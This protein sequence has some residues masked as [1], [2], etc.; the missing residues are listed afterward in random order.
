MKLKVT[1][2][3][4]NPDY[5]KEYADKY[6]FGEESENNWKDDW[7]KQFLLDIVIDSV[8]FKENESYLFEGKLENRE[9]PIK[10]KIPNVSILDAI[11]GKEVVAKFIVSKNLIERTHQTKGNKNRFMYF[12]FYFKQ[13][14]DYLNIGNTMYFLREDL[15]KELKEYMGI[16]EKPE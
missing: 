4:Q 14:T 8:S 13:G 2:K 16:E 9:H 7:M 12:Y 1:F 15:P 5:S 6:H 3:Q 11:K 10:A